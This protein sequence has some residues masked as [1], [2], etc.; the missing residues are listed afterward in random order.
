MGRRIGE[1][2]VDQDAMAGIWHIGELGDIVAALQVVKIILP[3]CWSDSFVHA[4]CSFEAR[5][6]RLL[7]MPKAA[8]NSYLLLGPRLCSRHRRMPSFRK[9]AP[10]ASACQALEKSALS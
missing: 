7:R 10:A 9:S 3:P 8:R 6:W 5:S 4:K 1:G 2:A